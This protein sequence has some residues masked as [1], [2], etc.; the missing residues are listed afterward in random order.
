[1]EKSHFRWTSFW[2]AGHDIIVDPDTIHDNAHDT[3]VGDEV[4]VKRYAKAGSVFKLVFTMIDEEL[5]QRVVTTSFLT[6]KD[7]LG[8]FVKIPPKWFRKPKREQAPSEGELP[9]GEPKK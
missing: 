5:N 3:I 2:G 8:E 7:R 9:F 1:M 6:Q 4:Y